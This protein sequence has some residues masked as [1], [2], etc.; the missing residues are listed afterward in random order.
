MNW[1]V[2]VIRKLFFLEVVEGFSDVYDDLEYFLITNNEIVES[3]KLFS[4]WVEEYKCV[5]MLKKW[6]EEK[7]LEHFYD[8][9]YAPTGRE[10]RIKKLIINDITNKDTGSA[11]ECGYGDEWRNFLSDACELDA[12]SEEYDLYQDV[13]YE[14]FTDKE[15]EKLWR[16]SH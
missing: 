14:G 3:K 4:E 5:E 13:L 9:A 15:L 1:E 11:S 10:E 7:A 2:I 8:E 12:D 16:N 6:L